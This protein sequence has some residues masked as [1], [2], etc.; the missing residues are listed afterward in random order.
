MEPN[1]ERETQD[2]ADWEKYSDEELSQHLIVVLR[3]D[4]EE[5]DRMIAGLQ[6]LITKQQAILSLHGLEDSVNE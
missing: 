4:I 6:A 5:R 3:E 2:P 1:A